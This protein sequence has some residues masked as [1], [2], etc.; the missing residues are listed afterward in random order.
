MHE[1][2]A[3]CLESKQTSILN[4]NKYEELTEQLNEA[5]VLEMR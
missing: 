3:S 5:S 2:T 4:K 1:R